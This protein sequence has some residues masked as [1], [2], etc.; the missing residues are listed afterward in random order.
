MNAIKTL[1]L[2]PLFCLVLT[3]CG[4]GGGSPA[5]GPV[6]PVANLAPVIGGSQA[7]DLLEGLQLSET[8]SFSD[9]ENDSITT[10]LSGDDAALMALSSDG[11]LTFSQIPDFE[12]AADINADNVYDV[13]I[14]ASDGANETSYAISITVANATEGRVV[15]GPVSGSVV[16]VDINGDGVQG[17]DEP[18]GTTDA[19][20]YF[21]FAETPQGITGTAVI[22]TGGTDTQTGVELESLTLI[23]EISTSADVVAV[24]PLTTV[25]VGLPDDT[26]KLAF[27]TAIGLESTPASL[28]TSDGWAAAQ[29]GDAASQAEQRASQQIAVVLQGVSALT[30]DNVTKTVIEQ[31]Q[32]VAAKIAKAS[33][34]QANFSLSSTDS[35]QTIVEASLNETAPGVYTDTTLLTAVAQ[36]VAAVNTVVADVTIDPTSVLAG[37]VALA[38]QVD[39][40]GSLGSLASG[41][42]DTSSYTEQTGLATLLADA[43]IPVDA[44]D[45]DGDGISDILDNDNDGDGVVDIEDVFPND[46]TET[47]DTDGDGV[48]NNVDEDNDGDGVVDIEDVF[49]NDE[50]ETTDTDGDGVGNNVDED[51]LPVIT[52]NGAATVNHE[53]GTSYTDAG[54]TATDSVEGTLTVTVSGVVDST[55][56]GSYI[57][58]FTAINSAGNSAVAVSRTVTVSDTIAPVITFNEPEGGS[59]FSTSAT[60]ASGYVL[61]DGDIG[62]ISGLFSA[63]DAVDGSI[64]VT[65]FPSSVLLPLGVNVFTATATDAAGNT[66]TFS[67]TIGV[68]DDDNPN[69]NVPVSISVDSTDGL[70]VSATQ[71]AIAAFLSA[72][73]ANDGIDGTLT[74]TTDAP[75]TFPLGSTTVTF[76]A[77]D[78]G[79]NERTKTAVVT[80]LNLSSVREG[81]TLPTAITV[82]ET[83]E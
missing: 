82:I 8:Y 70:G 74:V 62:Y 46:E 17:S 16:F 64:A 67:F 3:S 43:T 7:V 34:E 19:N 40:Q 22:A 61:T 9:P 15:D 36:S 58:T 11:N 1:G 30:A 80:V 83:V 38:V 66:A 52:L 44:P 6:P 60:S 2:V 77:V 51:V 76:T 20:G 59:D 23:S 49:P 55:I 5:P 42:I 18:M 78:A 32:V 33:Q 31:A 4:G 21:S 41:D 79:G 69:L 45:Q 53:Q 50:T 75:A 47:T 65:G 56:A 25:L 27:L 71:A 39:M 72:A 48:G 14:V 37:E 24:T 63:I 68:F 81:Y 12:A 54:A 13:N 26:Q 57:L 35:I 29:S 73:T 28:L 10:S